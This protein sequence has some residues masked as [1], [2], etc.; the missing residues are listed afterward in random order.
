[1]LDSQQPNPRKSSR[2][3]KVVNTPPEFKRKLA[4]FEAS[5]R[6][7]EDGDLLGFVNEDDGKEPE[8]TA[9]TNKN[10]DENGG[11][12]KSKP[13]NPV[14]DESSEVQE[15]S[16]GIEKVHEAPGAG[17]IDAAGGDIEKGRGVEIR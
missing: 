11:G 2:K 6:M 3:R 14:D 13:D 15:L 7:N 8:E 4:R 9:A 1:M 10:G 17:I 5:A 12:E 16:G